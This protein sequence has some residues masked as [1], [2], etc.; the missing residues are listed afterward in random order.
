MRIVNMKNYYVYAS[1]LYGDYGNFLFFDD[2]PR[3]VVMIVDSS[4]AS[5]IRGDLIE[6]WLSFSETLNRTGKIVIEV[7]ERKANP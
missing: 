2:N 1:L 5:F 7:R 4:V 6:S 3:R